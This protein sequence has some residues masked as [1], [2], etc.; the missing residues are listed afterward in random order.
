MNTTTDNLFLEASRCKLRFN[1]GRGQLSVEDLWDLSLK[2][3]DK[4]AVAIDE[5]IKPQRK[6]FLENPDRSEARRAK[7]GELALEIVKAII[8][9]MQAENKERL[10]EASKRQ[11]REFL[12]GLLEKKQID[13]L[14]SLSAADIEKELA[15][16]DA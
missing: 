14:E 8:A 1:T 10:A 13:A 5:E 3:L 15:A 9:V 7:E 11:R 12:Q 6:S 4:A 2:D 16:L